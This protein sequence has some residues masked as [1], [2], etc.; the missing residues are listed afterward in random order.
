MILIV[1]DVPGVSVAFR[2]VIQNACVPFQAEES[3]ATASAPISI[4]LWTT[5]RLWNVAAS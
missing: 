3:L 4:S 2:R 1:D 5:T